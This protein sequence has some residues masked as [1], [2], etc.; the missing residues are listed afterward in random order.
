MKKIRLT[1]DELT[2]I[3]KRV[4]KEQSKD[5]TIPADVKKKGLEFARM[6]QDIIDAHMEYCKNVLSQANLPG[7]KIDCEFVTDRFKNQPLGV[8][9]ALSKTLPNTNTMMDVIKSPVK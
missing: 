5:A 6:A 4:I 3:I 2:N 1:E 9:A 7:E 8:I